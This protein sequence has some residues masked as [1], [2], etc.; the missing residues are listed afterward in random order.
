MSK[1]GDAWRRSTVSAGIGRRGG[2]VRRQQGRNLRDLERWQA[3]EHVGE[4]GGG[5]ETPSTT[6]HDQGVED[7]APPAGVRMADEEPSLAADSGGPNVVL[8]EGMP[9]AGLC[10]AMRMGGWIERISTPTIVADAA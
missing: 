10:R 5:I 1:G 2:P 6:A 7:R 8:D 9:P 3:P 4:I